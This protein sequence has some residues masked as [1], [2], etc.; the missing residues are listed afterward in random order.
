LSK[1]EFEGFEIVV[2]RELKGFKE[3]RIVTDDFD[4]ALEIARK[5]AEREELEIK[6]ILWL[7]EPKGWIV[8]LSV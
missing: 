3:M 1:F 7:R 2:H 8:Y 5:L 6:G 4:K